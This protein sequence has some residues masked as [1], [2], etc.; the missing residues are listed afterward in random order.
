MALVPDGKAGQREAG[1]PGTDG[2]GEDAA[3]HLSSLCPGSR[4][5]LTWS[6]SRTVSAKPTVCMATPTALA[7]AKMR[8]MEPP[9]SGPRLREMRKYVPPVGDRVRSH[10]TRGIVWLGWTWGRQS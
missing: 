2:V 5:C 1:R 10:D 4:P 7:K 3:G 9:S 6:R 8:P